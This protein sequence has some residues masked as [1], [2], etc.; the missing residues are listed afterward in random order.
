MLDSESSTDCESKATPSTITGVGTVPFDDRHAADPDIWNRPAIQ[1]PDVTPSLPDPTV[2]LSEI[3]VAADDV[4]E[5]IGRFG[6][7]M[8][9]TLTRSAMKAALF[10]DRNKLKLLSLGYADNFICWRTS[11]VGQRYCS[12]EHGCF[13]KDGS[14]LLWWLWEPLIELSRDANGCTLNFASAGRTDI[15]M[16]YTIALRLWSDK[17]TKKIELTA[18]YGDTYNKRIILDAPIATFKFPRKS[19]Q[20]AILPLP[21]DQ[22]PYNAGYEAM[23]KY[24]MPREGSIWYKAMSISEEHEETLV[25][26][27]AESRKSNGDHPVMLEAQDLQCKSL[28]ERFPEEARNFVNRNTS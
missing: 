19:F 28:V 1:S 16:T 12:S 17:G 15:D 26:G 10:P 13:R 23:F 5:L 18:A 27:L 8:A 4:E 14:P 24:L 20:K 22:V 3:Q 21:I 7:K 11:S 2:L 25:E 9:N 6:R